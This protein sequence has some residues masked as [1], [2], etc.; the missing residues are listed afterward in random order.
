MDWTD[1]MFT[2]TWEEI[3]EEN[4][5]LRDEFEQ[6]KTMLSI[7]KVEILTGA[8]MN[9]TDRYAGGDFDRELKVFT[10]KFQGEERKIK[11]FS[12]LQPSLGQWVTA[13]PRAGHEVPGK[14]HVCEHF[15]VAETDRD[16]HCN[17]INLLDLKYLLEQI[18]K[19]REHRFKFIF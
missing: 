14:C 12:F 18:K 11:F 15:N 19:M 17:G 9:I 10:V 2:Q 1:K 6:K 13:M 3:L 8:K 16:Y 7:E 4:P 5:H